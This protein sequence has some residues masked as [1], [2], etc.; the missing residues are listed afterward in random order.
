MKSCPRSVIPSLVLYAK[1]STRRR[2]AGRPDRK[3]RLGRRDQRLACAPGKTSTLLCHDNDHS[4]NL[5]NPREGVLTHEQIARPESRGAFPQEHRTYRSPRQ[6]K[7][8]ATQPTFR[9][10]RPNRKQQA[11]LATKLLCRGR[12]I[13]VLNS[14]CFSFQ[15]PEQRGHI[16]QSLS[17]GTRV[18]VIQEV[19]QALIE[20]VL[21]RSQLRHFPQGPWPHSRTSLVMTRAEYANTINV[22][23]KRQTS[24]LMPNWAR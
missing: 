22:P 19:S 14:S 4:G 6:S 11:V 2:H 17:G 1:A 10:R 18:E 7:P 23:P 5:S 15:R 9:R 13:S 20:R 12:E 3:E 8:G 24:P 16:H 21:Q